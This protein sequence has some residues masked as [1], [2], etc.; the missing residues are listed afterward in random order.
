M[1]EPDL[2][3]LHGHKMLNMT[4]NIYE[5]DLLTILLHPSYTPKSEAPLYLKATTRGKNEIVKQIDFRTC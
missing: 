3:Y 4:K 1:I 5:G 2:S